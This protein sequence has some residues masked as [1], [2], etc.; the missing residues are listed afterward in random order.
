MTAA[1]GG[2]V[3]W[4]PN[5]RE[6]GVAHRIHATEAGRD[7]DMLRGK[8]P[9]YDAIC[10]HEDE[11]AEL[12]NGGTILASNHKCRVQAAEV[13]DGSRRFWGVQYH[14]EFELATVA[15]IIETHAKQLVNEGFAR[16]EHELA[17]VI[18]D[19]RALTADP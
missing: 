18:S 3:R 16:S 14:P 15:A 10:V 1:L 8:A 19:Y 13:R 9:A 17:A 12:P 11:V 7:H 4:C 6:V 2:D 5:G